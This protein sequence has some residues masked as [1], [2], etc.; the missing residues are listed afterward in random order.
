MQVSDNPRFGL[1]PVVIEV[2]GAML[3][4]FQCDVVVVGNSRKLEDL[5]HISMIGLSFF[6]EIENDDLIDHVNRVG[7]RL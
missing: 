2:L 6:S 7:V 3:S 4:Q 1:K 5:N